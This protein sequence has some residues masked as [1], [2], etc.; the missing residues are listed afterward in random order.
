MIAY[1][2]PLPEQQT[3]VLEHVRAVLRL[4]TSLKKGLKKPPQYAVT[5]SKVETVNSPPQS[6][7]TEKVPD[8]LPVLPSSAIQHDDN[9]LPEAPLNSIS[10]LP[11]LSTTPSTAQITTITSE[12]QSQPNNQVHEPA[13]VPCFVVD[14]DKTKENSV[15][16]EPAEME[17]RIETSNSADVSCPLSVPTNETPVTSAAFSTQTEDSEFESRM[18]EVEALLAI[19][20]PP[21][22]PYRSI[23]AADEIL[24][25][26]LLLF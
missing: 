2:E 23:Y 22:T 12:T 16:P 21:E 11:E 3:N 19:E 25:C 15:V 18:V 9:K 24:V 5:A 1:E 10:T 14:N 4:R 17:R 7:P 8:V 13:N 6:N 26:G 20:D